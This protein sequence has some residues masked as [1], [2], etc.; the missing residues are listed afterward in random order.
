MG[1][2]FSLK[3]FVVV[4][5]ASGI[6]AIGLL[7]GRLSVGQRYT[8][9]GGILMHPS[10]N[11]NIGIRVEA[12]GFV[13]DSSGY[14][15]VGYRRIIDTQN[16]KI[17]EGY[18]TYDGKYVGAQVVWDTGGATNKPSSLEFYSQN[19]AYLPLTLRWDINEDL[20][21]VVFPH[22]KSE[23]AC[24]VLRFQFRDGEYQIYDQYVEEPEE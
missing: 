3:L 10:N 5:F 1:N 17:R 13:R 20:A 12:D 2:K 14:T 9:R 11:N 8:P 23:G 16:N 4:L 7:L 6:F 24:Y 21:L 18:K 15:A 22:D 19:G